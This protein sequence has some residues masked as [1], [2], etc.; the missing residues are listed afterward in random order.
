MASI[1]PIQSGQIRHPKRVPD[2]LMKVVGPFDSETYNKDGGSQKLDMYV[3]THDFPKHHYIVVVDTV[4]SFDAPG[5]KFCIAHLITHST[6]FDNLKVPADVYD[7]I[8]TKIDL[9]VSYITRDK[10]L[11]NIQEIEMSKT[12]GQFDLIKLKEAIEY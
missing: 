8:T 9:T 4:E 3:L 5:Q 7:P 11:V 1:I 6:N 2:A 12:Y 10:F